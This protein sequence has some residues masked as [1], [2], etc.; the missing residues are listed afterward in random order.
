[1][2]LKETLGDPGWTPKHWW[3]RAFVLSAYCAVWFAFVYAIRD[4]KYPLLWVAV[5]LLVAAGLYGLWWR[6]AMRTPTGG[7]EPAEHGSE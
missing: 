5:G 7:T 2:R 6:W 3:G 4:E 1:M